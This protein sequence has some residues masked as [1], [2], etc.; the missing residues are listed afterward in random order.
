[1]AGRASNTDVKELIKY[2]KSLGFTW[3]GKLTGKGHIRLVHRNGFVTM[4]GT[5]SRG[6]WKL[7]ARKDIDRV[8]GLDS[9]NA[10]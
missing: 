5:P 3:D 7:K 2:A 10:S 8:A 4:A 9:S 1:M 6:Y